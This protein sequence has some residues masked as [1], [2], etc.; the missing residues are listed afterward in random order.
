VRKIAPKSECKV[1]NT[2]NGSQERKKGERER[3]KATIKKGS[4]GK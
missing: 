2:Y 4:E 3:K 1:A